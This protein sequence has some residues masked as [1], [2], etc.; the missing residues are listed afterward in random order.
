MRVTPPSLLLSRRPWARSRATAR[1]GRRNL[2]VSRLHVSVFPRDLGCSMMTAPRRLLLGC[3]ADRDAT[4][5]QS[6]RRGR[7][8][9]GRPV[10][11]SVFVCRLRGP[12]TQPVVTLCGEWQRARL[13]LIGDR[14]TG[15]LNVLQGSHAA[16]RTPHAA[17]HRHCL[18]RRAVTR[19]REGHGCRA[20]TAR[21]CDRNRAA[22]R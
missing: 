3:A 16:R 13:E 11:H 14:L 22:W 15:C 4:A 1:S 2:M 9:P 10:A 18:R 17:G 7:S 5:Q 21:G 20:M 6:S 12:R 19:R 8:R